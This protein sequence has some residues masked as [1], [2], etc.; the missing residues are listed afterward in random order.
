MGD[1][2]KPATRADILRCFAR[3]AAQAGLNAGE[4]SVH[5]RTREADAWEVTSRTLRSFVR[6][7]ANHPRMALQGVV[8]QS[9]FNE[10]LTDIYDAERPT[11]RF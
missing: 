11:P 2:S 10:D 7:A 8:P 4:A 5:G 6:Y 3:L 9:L 1:R